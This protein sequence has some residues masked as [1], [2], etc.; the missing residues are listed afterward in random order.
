M[1]DEKASEDAFEPGLVETD[2]VPESE[3]LDPVWNLHISGRVSHVP[4][5]CPG[6]LEGQV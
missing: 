1:E 2:P 6:R 4:M 3:M 5:R